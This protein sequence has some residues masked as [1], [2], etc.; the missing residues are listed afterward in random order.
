MNDEVGGGGKEGWLFSFLCHIL[1]AGEM[2]REESQIG[3]WVIKRNPCSPFCI[4]MAFSPFFFLFPFF[5]VLFF[6]FMFLF[7][8]VGKSFKELLV[9]YYLINF[10]D[11]DPWFTSFFI[12]SYWKSWLLVRLIAFPWVVIFPQGRVWMNWRL[13]QQGQQLLNSLGIRCKLVY[14]WNLPPGCWNYVLFAFK[15]KCSAAHSGYIY[16]ALAGNV[17]NW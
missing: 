17:S 14:G 2:R 7:W 8:E 10:R 4:W 15:D 3:K 5:L 6:V 1:L 12:P 11:M 13:L 16:L 9:S